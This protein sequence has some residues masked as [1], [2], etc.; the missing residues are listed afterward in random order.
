MLLLPN[1]L[2]KLR[3]P[4]TTC[5][6]A[7]FICGSRIPVLPRNQLSRLGAGQGEEDDGG[8]GT[9]LE[10]LPVATRYLHLLIIFG[11]VAAASLDKS[12]IAFK[13]V[14]RGGGV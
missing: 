3:K 1:P 14:G 6:A 9:N 11:V 8:S 2:Q 12:Y 13:T 10:C 7:V 4:P 5:L